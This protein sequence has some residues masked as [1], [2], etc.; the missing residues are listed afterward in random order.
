M[1]VQELKDNYL[2]SMGCSIADKY[3][4]IT[5]PG[6]RYLENTEAGEVRFC[7]FSLPLNSNIRDTYRFNL[8]LKGAN[9]AFANAISD[10]AKEKVTKSN[11]SG[12]VDVCGFAVDS[13]KAFFADYVKYT[14]KYIPIDEPTLQ[15]IITVSDACVRMLAEG[16]SSVLQ[17][18]NMSVSRGL[19]EAAR[20]ESSLV[21]STVAEASA[22]P[23]QTF[24]TTYFSPAFGGSAY[25]FASTRSTMSQA[26]INAEMAAH[27]IVGKICADNRIEAA[28]NAAFNDVSA[29]IDSTVTRFNT[30]LKEIISICIPDFL[31]PAVDEE[32]EELT[33]NPT[34]INSLYDAI[35]DLPS[36]E[37]PE[38]KRLVEYYDLPF[39]RKLNNKLGLEMFNHY[40][41]TGK[42]DFD[43]NRLRFY[44]YLSNGGDDFKVEQT[45]I[46]I[47]NNIKAKTKE[48]LKNLYVQEFRLSMIEE[49][50]EEVRNC[51][52][53]PEDYRGELF[54]YLDKT[55]AERMA[56]K[57]EYKKKFFKEQIQVSIFIALVAIGVAVVAVWIK[58]PIIAPIAILIGILII[59]VTS[60]QFKREWRD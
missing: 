15:K 11:P 10:F 58:L 51:S 49:L 14:V 21:S 34:N 29:A 47:Y 32:A 26:K 4:Y 6:Y 12:I 36:G 46:R 3:V 45:A 41:E 31:H 50:R 27:S 17:K 9:T 52:Y 39:A 22:A 8:V 24:A 55:E 43:S 57:K 16:L 60:I 35:S 44:R 28:N 37:F 1:S 40:K 38:V 59:V 5:D 53:L 33:S 56:E 23:T 13:A 7:E 30:S 20:M 48:R 19:A 54:E 42:C 18:H 2:L 25:T